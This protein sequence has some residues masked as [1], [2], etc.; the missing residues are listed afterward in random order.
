MLRKANKNQV[1]KEIDSENIKK[2]ENYLYVPV[3]VNVSASLLFKIKDLC[4]T[5]VPVNFIKS[6][7]P[8][9][10]SEENNQLNNGFTLAEKPLFVKDSV[11]NSDVLK[12]ND[13][14]TESSNSNLFKSIYAKNIVSTKGQED[15]LDFTA[16]IFFNEEDELRNKNFTIKIDLTEIKRKTT[17]KQIIMTSTDEESPTPVEYIILKRFIIKVYARNSNEEVIDNT[18]IESKPI[19]QYVVSSSIDLN[20]INVETALNSFADSFNIL[21][22]RYQFPIEENF[23][24]NTLL[25]FNIRFNSNWQ[26]IFENS[27]QDQNATSLRIGFEHE[28][29]GGFLNIINLNSTEDS[30]FFEDLDQGSSFAYS[31]INNINL[32]TTI[33]QIMLYMQDNRLEETKLNIVFCLEYESRE[34][35]INKDLN[36]SLSEIVQLYEDFLKYRFEI[37]VRQKRVITATLNKMTSGNIYTDFMLGGLY[38]LTI[39]I[40]SQNY[41]IED[42]FESRIS[43]KFQTEADEFNVSEFYFDDSLTIGNS[44][45]INS[46]NILKNYFVSGE[47]LN[48][49]FNSPTNSGSIISCSIMFFNESVTDSFIEIGPFNIQGLFYNSRQ[50]NIQLLDLYNVCSRDISDQTR[51]IKDSN[52]L[53][54]ISDVLN[55]NSPLSYKINMS[56]IV[57]NSNFKTLGYF[58][59]LNTLSTEDEIRDLLNNIIVVCKKSLIINDIEVGSRTFYN[60]MKNISNIIKE[61]NNFFVEIKNNDIPGLFEGIRLSDRIASESRVLEVI[62]SITTNNFENISSEDFTVVYEEKINYV[63]MKN[64]VV[65]MFGE[66]E[67]NQEEKRN[68]IDFVNTSNPNYNLTRLTQLINNLFSPQYYDNIPVLTKRIIDISNINN[69]FVLNS[70][71]ILNQE[72]NFENQQDSSDLASSL[73]RIPSS[74]LNNSRQRLNTSEQIYDL[75]SNVFTNLLKENVKYCSTKIKADLFRNKI[76]LTKNDINRDIVLFDENISLLTDKYLNSQNKVVKKAFFYADL[77]F[78]PDYTTRS[79]NQNSDFIFYSNEESAYVTFKKSFL[80]KYAQSLNIKIENNRIIANISRGEINFER[81]DSEY[82][83]FLSM[84][85]NSTTLRNRGTFRNTGV[86]KVPLVVKN[87]IFRVCIVLNIDNIDYTILKNI[88]IIPKNKLIEYSQRNAINYVEDYLNINFLDERLDIFMPDIIYMGVSWWY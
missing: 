3:K 69:L 53:N 48:L 54:L 61:N 81:F 17:S 82:Y 73:L 52:D 45:F 33:Q 86:R 46:E 40:D 59:V 28:E 29:I 42:I 47:S 88:P 76:I 72:D 7:S 79:Q 44:I 74:I 57:L 64:G 18:S 2:D 25:G 19:D 13:I 24:N 12:L 67:N 71:T 55:K 50:T 22:N 34:F 9:E 58:S 10:T 16:P 60:M 84:L 11:I 62:N 77:Q 15:F 14:V 51:I 87:I 70:T 65:S 66:S 56:N 20:L 30:S 63:L 78:N 27:N 83:S 75:S 26:R 31:S 4:A 23:N 85:L 8:N 80:E 49:Y 21:F 37:D 68:F 39:N 32:F 35:V 38:K 41:L 1:I 5:I 43:L 6:M 36:V